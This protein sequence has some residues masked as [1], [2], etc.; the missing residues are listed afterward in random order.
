M[1]NPSLP[2]EAAA[3]VDAILEDLSSRRRIEAQKKRLRR[4]GGRAVPRLLF[5]LERG[6]ERLRS[7]VLFSLQFAYDPSAHEPLQKLLHH[8]HAEMRRMAAIVLAR[9]EGLSSLADSCLSLLEH[10]H[11]AIVGMALEILEMDRPD[12]ERIERYLPRPEFWPFLGKSL[13][14]YRSPSLLPHLGRMLDSDSSAIRQ[15]AIATLLHQNPPPED[16]AMRLKRAL[17]D[18][19]PSVREL[20]IEYV[21]WQGTVEDLPLLEKRL[22]EERDPYCHASLQAAQTA[23][24]RRTA[25][26][27]RGVRAPSLESI[28]VEPFLRYEGQD[29][30]PECVSLHHAFL[31]KLAH[32]FAIPAWLPERNSGKEQEGKADDVYSFFPPIRD[33]FHPAR[34]SYG[35]REDASVPGFAHR[36]HVGDDVGWHRV[37]QGVFSIAAGVVRLIASLP[38]WGVLIVIE[39]PGEGEKG[40]ECFCSLYAH[41]HP[42][43]HVEVGEKVKA[44]QKIGSIGRA[45]TWENGGY[46]SHLHFAIHRGPFDACYRVGQLLDV[47]V[48][49]RTRTGRV[50]AST[51][52]STLVEIR[53]PRG[54]RCISRS[55]SWLAG[56]VSRR[57]FRE[58]EHGWVDPQVFLGER[59]SNG[60]LPSDLPSREERS[61]G[62]GT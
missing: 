30:D 28:R 4:L 41:L 59:I 33:Y 62:S 7:L 27:K 46:P 21:A 16:V 43:V 38:S 5:H 3:I 49:K 19:D 14:R 57:M 61:P 54:V 48:G 17:E 44:G 58:E 22:L 53:M 55:P 26:R 37:Q 9:Q 24:R 15:Y 12:L 42:F 29:F 35:H 18:A 25:W 51:P 50:V 20:A 52:F 45:F 36:V 6:D 11:P 56:Y 34:H 60:D 39:H 8:P 10:P 1:L 40:S 32:Y 47:K 2:D 13:P 31:L 23:I